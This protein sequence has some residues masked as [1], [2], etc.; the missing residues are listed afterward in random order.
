MVAREDDDR[1][2]GR[3]LDHVHV[4]EDRVGGPAIPLGDTAACDVRL[5]ELD[6]AGVAVEVPG[7]PEPD[8]VVQR[9]RVV[10]RQDEHIVD[11]RVH[12]VRQREVDDPVLAAERD[13]RLGAHGREDREALAFAAGEDHRHRPLHGRPPE[14]TGIVAPAPGGS[15]TG[16]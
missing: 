12:A 3:A 13:R 14:R 5:K 9:V 16:R 8:V 1:V 15:V 11:V 10:L 6:A 4:P 2:G 7:S